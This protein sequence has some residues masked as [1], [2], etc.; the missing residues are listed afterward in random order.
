MGAGYHIRADSRIGT[1]GLGGG[2]TLV[3]DGGKDSMFC[4]FAKIVRASSMDASWGL[5]ILLGTSLSAA[6]KKCMTWVILSSAVTW[7]CVRYACK[8]SA[9]SV[10]SSYLVLLSISWMQR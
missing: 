3:D 8:Y 2:N 5:H 6:D 1:I 10:I 9:G 7:G 4:Q